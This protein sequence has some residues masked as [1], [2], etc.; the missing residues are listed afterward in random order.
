MILQL[1]AVAGLVGGLYEWSKGDDDSTSNRVQGHSG[2]D[3]SGN[4]ITT[5]IPVDNTPVS[6]AQANPTNYVPPNITPTSIPSSG[7]LVISPIVVTSSG[8]SSV[9]VSSIKDVQNALNT[10]GFGPLNADNILGPLTRSAVSRYQA[11]RG[12]NADG[13]PGNQTR[14]ALNNDLLSLASPNRAIG[15]AQQVMNA[16]VQSA[17][18][19]PIVTNKDI[20]HA[21]NMLG[22][23]PTLLEDGKI[24]RVSVAAI[25]AFQLLHGMPVDGIA[26][27]AVRTALMLA[28]N[29]PVGPPSLM[30]GEHNNY[31]PDRLHYWQVSPPPPEDVAEQYLG[32]HFSDAR[33]R[34][35]RDD[36]DVIA[37]AGDEKD[38]DW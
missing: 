13:V 20:Q 38:Y 19:L 25:K 1:L 15:Q 12:L 37:F 4:P 29:N 33:Q 18:Q 22:A 31:H 10:L 11:S 21:L 23:Q 36:G 34:L 7:P 28:M 35:L 17:A 8:A 26:S 3:P 5:V 24:D 16:T 14:S 32:I 6:K 2:K 30:H 27:P 9:T